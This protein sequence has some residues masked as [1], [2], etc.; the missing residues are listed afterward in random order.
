L[1]KYENTPWWLPQCP[2]GPS[3]LAESIKG[4]IKGVCDRCGEGTHA[5]RQNSKMP[6]RFLPPEINSLY[7]PPDLGMGYSLP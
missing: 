5:G 1:L 6:S 2:Q 3:R 7:M 4:V